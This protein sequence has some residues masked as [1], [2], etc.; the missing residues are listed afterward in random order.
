MNFCICVFLSHTPGHTRVACVDTAFDHTVRPL[1]VS[2]RTKHTR[3][4]VS[5]RLP[6]AD[7]Q[8]GSVGLTRSSIGIAAYIV[9][10]T[11]QRSFT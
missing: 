6:G 7:L 9:K 1:C 2:V 3:P 11:V 8:T 4:K 5:S 10:L